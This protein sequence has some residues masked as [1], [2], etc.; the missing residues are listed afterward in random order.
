MGL[1]AH[2]LPAQKKIWEVLTFLTGLVF[3]SIIRAMTKTLDMTQHTQL[4]ARYEHVSMLVRE[5]KGKMAI[6]RDLTKML[7]TVTLQYV[8]VDQ[9]LV[10]CRRIKYFSSLYQIQAAELEALID[11][12]EKRITWASLL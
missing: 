3:T 8:K 1:R 5:F 4:V 6:K 12:L 11:N 2:F 9:I 7:K 10:D